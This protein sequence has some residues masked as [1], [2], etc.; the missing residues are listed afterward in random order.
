MIPGVEPS[1]VILPCFTPLSH[2]LVASRLRSCIV[3]STLPILIHSIFFL[4][5]CFKVLL[6][7]GRFLPGSSNLLRIHWSIID[8]NSLVASYATNYSH[9]SH[10]WVPNY[11]LWLHH[12]LCSNQHDIVHISNSYFRSPFNSNLKTINCGPSWKSG[13]CDVHV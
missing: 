13:G 11:L 5:A 3:S 7:Q 6:I 2:K 10:R 9:I 12:W 4:M 8:K 1:K